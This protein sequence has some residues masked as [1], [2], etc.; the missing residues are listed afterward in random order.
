[1]ILLRKN[2]KKL[3][4]CCK[5]DLQGQKT[6]YIMKFYKTFYIFV[7][8]N[9]KNLWIEVKIN[10]KSHQSSFLSSLLKEVS[11]PYL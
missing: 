11:L 3:F 5:T 10:L 6:N 4:L 2:T 1:M 9:M 8:D 7:P